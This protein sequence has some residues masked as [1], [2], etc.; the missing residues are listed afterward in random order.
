MRELD[1]K[2]MLKPKSVAIIG[3]SREP[4]KIGHI[5]LQNYINAGY[6]GRLYVVNKNADEVMGYKSYKSVLDIKD[7]LDLVVIAIP[8]QFVPQAMEECGRA[9][10]KTVVVVSGGFAEVGNTDL[11]DQL[12]AIAE[13]Y[14]M[15]TLG[16]NCLGVMDP[17]SRSDTLFLPT[18]K[19]SK[20]Q[21]GGVSFVAQSG[22]VGSTILDLINGEGFGLSKFISYGNA[23]HVDEVD[24]LNY[25]MHDDET[26][27][28]VL[29]IEGIKRGKDFVEIAKKI[30]KIKPVVI[31]KAGRTAAGA[32]AARSHTA[33]L[34]GDF[35]SQEAIF[36][37]FGFTVANDLSELLHYAKIFVSEKMPK[38]NRIAIITNGGGAGV[39]TTDAIAASGVL[40]L[41]DFSDK[42]KKVLQKAMPPLVNIRNPLDLAGDADGNRYNDALIPLNEDNNIDMFI[43][44]A[45]FQ[46]PGADSKLA[47]RLIEFKDSTDKPVIALS[48]GA[49]YTEMHKIMMESAGLPVY[50]SPAAAALSLGGLYRY[51]VYKSRKS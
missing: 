29:Y 49:E 10:V 34:A 28:I 18:Y 23:A 37:Q 22:A 9:K 16:P 24:I 44:I 11:Q 1:L 14:N 31:L 50:D 12:A 25:L 35:E 19:L 43:V 3:A 7:S 33:A 27:V 30:T 8:A 2:P 17:R 6:D 21:I 15:P 20:P 47:A 36:R 41:A 48:I 45:L 4:E 5:I 40:Q 13:K 39:L 32:S 42:T 46:T 38:G 26:K 51:G